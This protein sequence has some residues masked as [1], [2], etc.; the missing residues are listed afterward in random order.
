MMANCS[1]ASGPRP[2]LVRVTIFQGKQLLQGEWIEEHLLR[3]AYI[4]RPELR[5]SPRGIINAKSD[6]F[7]ESACGHVFNQKRQSFDLTFRRFIASVTPA[8]RKSNYVPA[9]ET[10]AEAGESR[11]CDDKRCCA[12]IMWHRA[13]LGRERSQP[14]SN[15][16]S[17]P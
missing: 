8:R 7:G 11:K 13:T 9:S 17:M 2:P 1:L 12:D 14:S 15:S 3:R 4:S 6:T 16:T 5:L 10:D